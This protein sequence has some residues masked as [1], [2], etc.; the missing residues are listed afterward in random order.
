MLKVLIPILLGAALFFT[1]PPQ[2]LEENAWQL[3]GLFFATIVGIILKPYPMPVV[4]L[5]GLL[6]VVITKTLTFTEAFSGF[7]SPILWLI[8]FAYFVAHGFIKSGLGAR[9]SYYFLGLMGRRT[10]GLAYGLTATEYL[11]ASTVPSSAARAGGI[12]YPLVESLSETYGSKPHDPTSRR[13]GSYLSLV[14]F[15]ANTITGAMFLTAMAANPLIAQISGDAGVAMSWGSWALAALVPGVISLLLVPL[16]IY[17]LHPPEVKLTPD[18][19]RLAKLKL[20]EMGPMKKNEWIM[21]S[22]FILLIGLWMFGPFIEISPTVTAHLGLILL[23]FTGVVQWKGLVKEEGAWDT[24]IW[25]SI[26]LMMGTQLNYLGFTQWFG[27]LVT[28]EVQDL[29]TLVAIVVALLT[30]FYSH[31]FFASNTAHVGAMFAPF[32]FVVLKLGAPAALAAYLLAFFSNLFGGLTHYG[33]G[34]AAIFFG[35]GFVSVRTWWVI[36]FLISV[37]NIA[38]WTFIGGAWW[39]LLGIW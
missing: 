1:P 13:I 36:G 31:Y 35:A 11:L 7:S 24:M 2:G 34:P 39:K 26:L 29:N 37:M 22:V 25:F 4:A 17:K 19:P 10:L 3:F 20:S 38:I 30:Y 23:L 15:Q 18:A 28:Y 27:D 16:V 12:I 14:A 32:L 8:V 9:I 6:A 33:S 21:L 5:A